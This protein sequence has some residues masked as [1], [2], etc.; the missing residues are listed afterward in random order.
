MTFQV[1]KN[2]IFHTTNND[3]SLQTIFL[4]GK[5]WN[6]LGVK[7]FLKSFLPP[8]SVC[9]CEKY[10][11]KDYNCLIQFFPFRLDRWWFDLMNS[12]LPPFDKVFY[13]PNIFNDSNISI[14]I[15][16]LRSFDKKFGRETSQIVHVLYI[17]IGDFGQYFHETDLKNW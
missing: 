12:F 15:F 14:T 11:H 7:N 6:S 10:T 17:R 16:Y 4:Q 3:L 8:S 9:L 13:P 2:V 5:I 1:L